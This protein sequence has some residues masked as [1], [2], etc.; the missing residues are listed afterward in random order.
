MMSDVYFV[1]KQNNYL[2]A[3]IKKGPRESKK[4]P[5]P[6]HVW[7]LRRYYYRADVEKVKTGL[8]YMYKALFK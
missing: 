6:D 4:R 2:P 8:V 3:I 5:T 1:G 7:L